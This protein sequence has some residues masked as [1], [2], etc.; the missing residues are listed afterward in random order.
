MFD[1]EEVDEDEGIQEKN[2]KNKQ[3]PTFKEFG[4]V[5]EHRSI[6]EE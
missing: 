4:M 5:L 3:K 6:Y 2:S 1:E